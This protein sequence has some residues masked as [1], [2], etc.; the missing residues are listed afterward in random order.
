MSDDRL[1]R[2]FLLRSPDALTDAELLELLLRFT[3]GD[4]N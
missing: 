2:R 3:D 4:A 1:V